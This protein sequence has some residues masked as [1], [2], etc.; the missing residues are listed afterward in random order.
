MTELCF[1][2]DEKEATFKAEA[3]FIEGC[4]QNHLICGSCVA[5]WFTI[6]P[7]QIKEVYLKRIK[8]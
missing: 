5:Y 6:I 4:V 8:G 2:C 7:H 1:Y 3:E